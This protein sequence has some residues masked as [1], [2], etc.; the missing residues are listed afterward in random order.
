[1]EKQGRST[2]VAERASP[3]WATAT[4]A[5][6]APPPDSLAGAIQQLLEN[7][8]IDAPEPPRPGGRR[9]TVD[10]KVN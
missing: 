10:L 2:P 1:L 8:R 6:A 3:P 9:V 5:L 7:P 4:I